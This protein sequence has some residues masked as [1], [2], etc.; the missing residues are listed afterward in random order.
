M[1][2]QR[3]QNPK[4]TGYWRYGGAGVTVC[5]Q[6]QTFEGFLADMGVAPS[7][8]HS[9]DR[10]PDKYGGYRPG[11]VRWA[12]QTEQMR[13]ARPMKGR[14]L[15][16]EAVA[17]IREQVKVASRKEVAKVFMVSKDTVTDIVLGRTWKGR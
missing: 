6:W 3:C 16:P 2:K 9:L 14:K 7:D 10:W 13:N 5:E 15:T 4:A 17:Q 11:N 1:M 8:K 12:T